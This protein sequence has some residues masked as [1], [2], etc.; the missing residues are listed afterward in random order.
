MLKKFILT[1]A[2]LFS[3]LITIYPSKK[4]N[5]NLFDYCYCLEKILSRNSVEKSKN[6]SKK[7]H[8]FAKDITAF[9]T[10]KTKG[11]LANKIIDQYKS[12]KNLFIITFLP[13][14]LYCFAGYW[15]EELNP[16]TFTSIFYEKSKQK[17]NEYKDI[18]KEVD[19]FIKD[20]D[21]EYKSIKKEI[22]DLF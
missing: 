7:V 9:G 17:I 3:S 10:N 19:K 11:D 5:T 21:S 8:S 12:S 4:E 22:N 20:I 6:L 14:E 1:S 2:L 13:N 16:G 18:K 15:I